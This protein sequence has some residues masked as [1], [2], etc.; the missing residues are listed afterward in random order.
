MRQLH[1]ILKLL[2][3]VFPY[4]G[5]KPDFKGFHTIALC[6]DKENAVDLHI[7]HLGRPWTVTCTLDEFETTALDVTTPKTEEE[8][9]QIVLD[10]KRKLEELA[11]DKLRKIKG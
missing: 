9:R 3:E 7:W 11:A 10:I 5:M 6:T 8:L 4:I 2:A 1:L